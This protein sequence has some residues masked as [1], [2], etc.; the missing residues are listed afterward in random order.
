MG[1]A[2]IYGRKINNEQTKAIEHG[3]GWVM[4]CAG[5]GAEG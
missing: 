1:N 2:L 5:V 3:R 4:V